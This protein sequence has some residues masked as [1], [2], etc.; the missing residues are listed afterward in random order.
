MPKI[1]QVRRLN[2]NGEDIGMGFNSD[3][4]LAVGTALDFDPPDDQISQESIADVTI[5]T[6]HEELMS[7]LH[8]AAQFEGRYGTVSGGAKVDFSNNTKYN[9]SSTFVVARLVI[10]NTVS[11]GR[12][13]RAKEMPTVQNL[14][15]PGR[16]DDFKTAFGDGFVRAQFRGG[17]FYAVMRITSVDS[18]TESNL[19]VALH[20]E[21]QGGPVGGADFKAEMQ[22]A[23][24]NANS[25]SEF[26]VHFYQKGGAGANEIGTTMDVDEIKKR[27]KVFPDAVKNHPYPYFIEVAT[28]DTVPLPIAGGEETEDFLLALKDAEEK[29]LKYLQ[30]KN[31]CEFAVEHPEYFSDLP[32]KAVLQNAQSAYTQIVNG[33]IAHAIKLSNGQLRPPTLF[34]PAKLDPPVAIPDITLRKKDLG[35]EASIAE[36]WVIKDNADTLKNDFELISD[37]ALAAVMDVN[38]FYDIKDPNGDP[39][40]TLRM[41]GRALSK[42]VASWQEYS[43]DH[44]GM[45]RADRGKLNT[46]AKLQSMLPK[47][48]KSLDFRRNAIQST[49]GLDA[50]H[51][52]AILDLS[53]NAINDVQEL[54]A[55]PF[56]KTLTLV[57]NKVSDISPLRNCVSL[58]TVD[59]SGNDIKDISPLAACKLL[60][61]L[62][63]SG[64]MTVVNG[65]AGRSGNP[66]EKAVGLA[67]VPGISNPFLIGQTLAIRFGLLADGPDAQFVGTAT[68]IGE[69]PSFRVHLTRGAEVMDDVWTLRRVFRMRTMASDLA[70]LPGIT[71]GDLPLSGKCI[72]IASEQNPKFFWHFGHVDPDDP[73]KARID[74]TKYP[75][76][77]T[78]IKIRTLDAVVQA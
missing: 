8:M 1:D 47:G 25:R 69:S 71:L 34:D 21:V 63:L 17:E 75:L 28:Y 66:L 2:Y 60:T 32:A 29:K 5:V 70:F 33:V 44:P 54:G 4:G 78:K 57:D 38:N 31:D 72:T 10:S 36:W 27:L 37:I 46:L 51:T 12:N 56:L 9:S 62:T 35:S 67:D 73:A 65:V 50:F 52:L 58:E 19:A 59:L 48:V 24:S 49:A 15:A 14:L 41:Q 74:L 7:K 68:R 23:N 39:V 18:S 20:A 61:D 26:S 6:S 76:F 11:R 77:A 16:A 13:F 53:Q 40:E 22:T 64:S 55:M 45:H 42:V 43:W 30:L 3:S